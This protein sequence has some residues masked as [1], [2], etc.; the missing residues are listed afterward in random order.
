MCIISKHKQ[1]RN[2][3]K[4]AIK[5]YHYISNDVI[6]ESVW[7]NINYQSVK[8]TFS[9]QYYSNGSHK[10]GLDIEYNNYKISNKTGKINLKKRIIEISSYRLTKCSTI[11]DYIKEIDRRDSN[12][13]YYFLLGREEK[14]N[15]LIYNGY[16]IPKNI[17]IL[18]SIK[19][20]D[21]WN[22]SPNKDLKHNFAR[23]VKNMSSQLWITLPLDEIEMYCV[24]SVNI[25]RSITTLNYKQIYDDYTSIII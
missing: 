20:K 1:I 13:D 3:F 12:F 2:E 8:D 5:G 17:D 4:K 14:E 6:K 7:E 16:I 22:I 15:K 21:K 19:D 10:S 23:I 11:E 18:K 24:F 9:I 25:D